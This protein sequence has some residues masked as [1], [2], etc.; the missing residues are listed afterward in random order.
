MGIFATQRNH[1]GY[2]YVVRV[3]S[4]PSLSGKT[5]NA[6]KRKVRGKM[7]ADALENMYADRIDRKVYR[8]QAQRETRRAKRK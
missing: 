2:E 8:A 1:K 7:K 5:A 3:V 4:A 6:S